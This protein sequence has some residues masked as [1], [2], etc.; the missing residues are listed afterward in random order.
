LCKAQGAQGVAR[1][2]ALTV[3]ADSVQIARSVHWVPMNETERPRR[4]NSALA[5]VQPRPLS[6]TELNFIVRALIDAGNAL[7]SLHAVRATE[8]RVGDVVKEET[9]FVIDNR[10]YMA[11]LDLA[12]RLLGWTGVSPPHLDE[13]L[14]LRACI[15]ASGDPTAQQLFE[16]LQHARREV[17]Q[18]HDRPKRG[19]PLF[20]DDPGN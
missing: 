17:R 3:Q 9:S 7:F 20:V 14:G 11:A 15:E 18:S 2:H 6:R 19:R 10:D 5:A 13:Q 16:R 8:S 12:E 4:V 1:L